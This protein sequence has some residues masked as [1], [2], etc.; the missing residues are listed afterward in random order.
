MK[1]VTVFLTVTALLLI[2]VVSASAAWSGVTGKI[3]ADDGSEWQYG[4]SV[5]A[6]ASVS[7]TYQACGSDTFAAADS[8][9]AITFSCAPDNYTAIYLE[10]TFSAGPG[11]TPPVKTESLANLTSSTGVATVHTSTQTGPTA[12]SLQSVTTDNNSTA[13]GLGFV[14]LMLA[15]VTFV[16]FRRR[17]AA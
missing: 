5:D 4:G 1:K 6:Y 11:G 13:I 17:E 16:M 14:V 15:G 2:A 10:F 8:D 7:G 12:V 3:F 9:Y